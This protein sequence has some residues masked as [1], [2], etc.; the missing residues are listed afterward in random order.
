MDV[1]ITQQ[2]AIDIGLNV[3]GYLAGGGLWFLLSTLF[4]RRRSEATEGTTAAATGGAVHAPAPAAI[5]AGARAEFL[6]LRSGTQPA[7]TKKKRDAADGE[8][9]TRRN[10]SEVFALA[11]T[12]LE[13]GAT[14]DTIKATVPISDGELALLT[15][16]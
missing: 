5:A 2:Q 9:G 8:P 16:K 6:D 4:Q 14:H 12:M 15:G 7:D 1:Q 11:R 10:H 3:A 13:K